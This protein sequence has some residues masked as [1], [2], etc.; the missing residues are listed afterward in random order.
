[1]AR[2][3]EHLLLLFLDLGLQRKRLFLKLRH[4]LLPFQDV[5]IPLFVH[6][7]FAFEL[8]HDFLE[9]RVIGLDELLRAQDRRFGK[10]ETAADGKGIA[11]ARHPRQQ[12][13]C[14]TQRLDIELHAG[15]LDA[16]A[17]KGERL[18]LR[19]MCRHDCRRAA[20]QELFENRHGKRRP[21]LGI[22][23]RTDFVDQ[24][25]ICPLSALQKLDHV[26]HVRRKCAEALLDALFIADDRV[27]A[28]IDRDFRA[29][30]RRDIAA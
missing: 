27:D 5:R 11:R 19:I 29:C 10:T 13:I 14:R 30:C 17:R 16:L 2:L 8:V 3:L 6:E 7:F 15:I 22:G 25:E 24:Q 9:L 12:A 1:M 21:F 4:T 26:R 18:Q 28:R 20:R 23:S